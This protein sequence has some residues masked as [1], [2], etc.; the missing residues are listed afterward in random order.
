MPHSDD[1][2]LLEA[3]VLFEM[4]R[5]TEATALFDSLASPIIGDIARAPSAVARARSWRLVHAANARAGAGDTAALAAMADTIEMLGAQTLSGRHQR[6]HHHVRGL[7]LAARGETAGAAEEFYSATFWPV[8]PRS[9]F[10]RT[11]LELGRVLIAL[12]RPDEAIRMLQPALRGG[13]ESAGLYATHTELHELLARAFD[14]A[15]QADNARVH[16]R[17]ALDAWKNADPE[18]HERRETLRVRLR[19]LDEV[20]GELQRGV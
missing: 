19:Q 17:W 10:T 20:G 12:D 15:G 16:Y 8:A 1:A 4:N 6:L 2:A 14:T 5:L 13:L 18:F 11:N 7:S 9:G 3:Q